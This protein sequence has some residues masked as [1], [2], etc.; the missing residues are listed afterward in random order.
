MLNIFRRLILERDEGGGGG[1]EDTIFGRYTSFN[2]VVSSQ[3]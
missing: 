3:N 2:L 1:G